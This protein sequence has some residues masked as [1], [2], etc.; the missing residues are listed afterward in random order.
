MQEKQLTKKCPYCAEEIKAEAIFCK[1]CQTDLTAGPSKELVDDKPKCPLC[2]GEMVKKHIELN[3]GGC[4]SLTIIGLLFLLF[5][6]IV[7][8]FAIIGIA[9]IIIGL[10]FG[11]VSKKYLVCKK[12]GNKNEAA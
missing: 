5:S 9:F 1:H 2:G 8:L 7:P 11:L 3:R 4:C 6:F 10:L 12:C